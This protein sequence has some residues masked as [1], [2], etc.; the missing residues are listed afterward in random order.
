MTTIRRIIAVVG[1]TS[2]IYFIA[3]SLFGALPFTHALITI[4]AIDH[5]HPNWP[6]PATV[7]D[8][9][10]VMPD[11]AC[12]LMILMFLAYIGA[13]YLKHKFSPPPPPAGIS[14]S[15]RSEVMAGSA[16]FPYTPSHETF[17]ADLIGFLRD[18]G[19]SPDKAKEAADTVMAT[20]KPQWAGEVREEALDLAGVSGLYAR[21]LSHEPH[22]EE[23]V[24]FL[25]DYGYRATRMRRV[26]PDDDGDA[27]LLNYDGL[28]VWHR[29][30]ASAAEEALIELLI[31]THQAHMASIADN[32]H[33]SKREDVEQYAKT[34]RHVCTKLALRGFVPPELDA[35][36]GRDGT[37]TAEELER[38]AIA[39]VVAVC[40]PMT[41]MPLPTVER[42]LGGAR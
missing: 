23:T 35:E 10:E 3:C 19:A 9:A 12:L 15:A 34:L 25:K 36:I 7:D 13:T 22:L 32:G 18:C 29:T 30:E 11:Y 27:H 24:Q 17:H 14:L 31:T 1:I 42:A 37:A 41:R 38:W 21:I 2:G 39:Q 6:D 20:G 28:L 40:S 26:A 5:W 16:V 8:I 33:P 4:T